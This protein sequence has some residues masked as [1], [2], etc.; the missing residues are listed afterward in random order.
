[1]APLRRARIDLAV[2]LSESSTS[3]LAAHYYFSQQMELKL[4]VV[5]G[6]SFQQDSKK[7]TGESRK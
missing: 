1:M 5:G 4:H 7:G 6:R 2:S 3:L